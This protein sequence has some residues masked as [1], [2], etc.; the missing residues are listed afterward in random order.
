M[1]KALHNCKDDLKGLVHIP[2]MLYFTLSIQKRL[3]ALQKKPEPKPEIPSRP[4]SDTEEV[5]EDQME[6]N[7]KITEAAEEAAGDD[8]QAPKIDDMNP[9][10]DLLAAQK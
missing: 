10:E 3:T 5:D 1:S 9:A 8:D 4:S 7:R 2:S 6:K